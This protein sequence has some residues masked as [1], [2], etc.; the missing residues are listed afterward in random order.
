[1]IPITSK[2]IKTITIALAIC[3]LLLIFPVLAIADSNINLVENPSFESGISIPMNWTFISQNGNTPIWDDA[4]YS[5]SKS[6]RINISGTTDHKSGYPQSDLI[7]AESL[8][9]YTVSVWGKTEN[10]GGTNTPAIRVVELDANKN[11]LNQTN[12][13]VFGRGTNDWEQKRMEFQTGSNTA[14]IYIYANIWNGYGTFWMDDIVL[15]LKDTPTPA[16][17]ATPV[18]IPG[19]AITATPTPALGSTIA[20]LGDARPSKFGNKGIT[21]LTAD[22]NQIIP[23]SPTGKVDAIFMIG[24]MD[25]VSQTVQA[26]K[27]SNVNTIPIYFVV[28]NHEIDNG[29]MGYI[30]SLTIPT[31]FKI[32]PAPPG[33][34]K[35]AFSVDIGDIHVVD[36]NI[37]W[38]GKNNDAYW[39]YGGTDGGWIAPELYN[40]VNQDLSSTSSWKVVLGHEPMYPKSRHVGDSLDADTTNRDNFEKLLVSKGVSLFVAAHTHYATVNL[41]DSVYHVDAGISGA[42]TVDGEDPYASITYTVSTPNDLTLTWKHENPT[43]SNPKVT[44]YTIRK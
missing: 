37:Y 39:K 29:D 23:Q 38:D 13:P 18:V 44:T 14:Y 3:N 28:G 11:W 26:Y 8:T 43:W 21:D 2:S 15:R 35:T 17:T 12:L 27:A 40:W 19:P 25:H 16:V 33:T 10:A 24:D 42:K 34:D 1:M 41:H 30:R 5:G 7:P 31:T 22:L 4:S 36:M 6:I 20:Y 32:N 9:T